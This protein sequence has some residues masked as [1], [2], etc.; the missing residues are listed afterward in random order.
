MQTPIYVS[1]LL[2]NAKDDSETSNYFMNNLRI[3][4]FQ[5]QE[6]LFTAKLKTKY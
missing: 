3:L 1:N 5:A 2:F 6:K 4:L